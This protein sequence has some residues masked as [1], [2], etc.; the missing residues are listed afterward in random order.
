MYVLSQ[1]SAKGCTTAVLASVGGQ[2][3]QKSKSLRAFPALRCISVR[4]FWQASSRR[5][6]YKIDERIQIQGACV[7]MIVQVV[8]L[9]HKSRERPRTSQVRRQDRADGTHWSCSTRP[10]EVAQHG[11]MNFPSPSLRIVLSDRPNGRDW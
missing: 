6:L 10:W 8:F 11:L 5:R 7:L 2:V 4:P 3:D 1:T 9:A